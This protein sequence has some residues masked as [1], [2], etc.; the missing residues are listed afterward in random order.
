MLHFKPHHGQSL[1]SSRIAIGG[2]VRELNQQKH[3]HDP[4]SSVT[5]PM[6]ASGMGGDR[7]ETLPWQYVSVSSAQA[8]EGLPAGLSAQAG[9]ADEAQHHGRPRGTAVTEPDPAIRPCRHGRPRG[10]LVPRARHRR[11]LRGWRCFVV[12][13]AFAVTR[14]SSAPSRPAVLEPVRYLGV[15]ERSVPGSYAGIDQFAQAIG[16]Q[17]D[18]APYYSSWGEPFQAGFAAAAAQHGAVP[19]VQINPGHVQLA[20]I[21]GGRYDAYLRRFADAVRGLPAPRHRRL[22]PRAE[23]MVVPV[24]LAARLRGVVRRGLAAHR[25]RVPRPGRSQRHLAVDHQHRRRP[26]WHRAARRVVAGQFVRDLGRHRRLLLPSRPGR[27]RR[28]SARPSRPCGS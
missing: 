1:D 17:P 18:L 11:D 16:K 10:K 26:G 3:H 22:R 15:Y 9:C 20:A 13:V 12:A 7:T 6:R 23:R 28:C 4:V 25:H 27:S 2:P 21:A 19:L 14:L 8:G 24:G 5:S